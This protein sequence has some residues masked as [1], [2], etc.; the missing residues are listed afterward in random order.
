MIYVVNKFVIIRQ[1]VNVGRLFFI[2]QWNYEVTFSQ[3]AG[4]YM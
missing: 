1:D 2:C 4:L 3:L